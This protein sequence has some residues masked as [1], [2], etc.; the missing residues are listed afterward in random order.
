M[1]EAN[2]VRETKQ[3]DVSLTHEELFLERKPVIKPIPTN[4]KPVE[5]R[6]EIKIPLKRERHVVCTT[7]GKGILTVI[8]GVGIESEGSTVKF[9]SLSAAHERVYKCNMCGRLFVKVNSEFLELR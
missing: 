5:T 2:P 1:N 3:I 9:Q 7:C 6:T 8:G 4:E